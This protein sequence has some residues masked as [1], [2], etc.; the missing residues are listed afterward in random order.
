MIAIGALS[1]TVIGPEGAFADSLATALKVDGD[2]AIKWLGK[3]ELNNYSF[4]VINR[5]VRTAWECGSNKGYSEK[6]KNIHAV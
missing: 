5:H 4:W 2:N 6:Q 1:A 3:P